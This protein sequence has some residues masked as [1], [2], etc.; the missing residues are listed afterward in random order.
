MKHILKSLGRN[1]LVKIAGKTSGYLSAATSWADFARER[2][3]AGFIRA[4]ANTGLA[5]VR[6]HPLVNIAGFAL[7]AS[8]RTDKAYYWLGERL[9]SGTR[10]VRDI[11]KKDPPAK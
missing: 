9:D 3:T 1:P 11:V 7:D 4:S 8:G 2:S 5:V 6:L 10:S